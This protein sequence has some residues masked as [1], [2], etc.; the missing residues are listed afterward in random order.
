MGIDIRASMGK[1]FGE[2][3]GIP[4]PYPTHG[5]PYP[6]G[7]ARPREVVLQERGID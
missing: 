2:G 3:M 1:L 6:F 7:S 5:R 4:S